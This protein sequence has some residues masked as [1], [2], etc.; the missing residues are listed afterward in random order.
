MIYEWISK[1]KHNLFLQFI[2]K[3]CLQA[4]SRLKSA[5]TSAF[6]VILDD[7]VHDLGVDRFQDCLYHAVVVD[8]VHSRLVDVSGNSDNC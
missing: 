8:F 2:E 4:F 1:I 7:L 5:S 3:V 6:E